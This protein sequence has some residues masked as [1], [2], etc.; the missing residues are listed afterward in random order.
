MKRI[1][2]ALSILS[3]IFV[4]FLLT[5][6]VVL[7]LIFQWNLLGFLT[8]YGISNILHYLIQFTS[9]FL[10]RRK[11]ETI[12]ENVEFSDILENKYGVLVVGHQ[13][14][15][16]Y[17]R[18]CLQKLDKL[19][20]CQQIIIVQDGQ[21][22]YMSEIV[23]EIFPNCFHLNLEKPFGE[24]SQTE[25]Q[26]FI[27]NLSS[28]KVISLTQPQRGKRDAMY[29]GFNIAFSIPYLKY[30]LCTD[31]DTWIESEAPLYLKVLLDMDGKIG[32]STGNVKIFNIHNFLS[33]MIDL[34][35]WFAFNLE[36]AAQSFF[37]CVSCVSGPLGMYRLSAVKEVL[38]NWKGQTFLG[39][40]TTFGDDRHMTNLL[41]MKGYKINYT[42]KAVCY[43]ETPSEFFRWLTQQTRWGRSFIREYFLGI[44]FFHKCSWWLL[45]D[46]TYLMFY[47]LFLFVLSIK[48]LIDI[49]FQ[50]LI[51]ILAA[52][53][54]VAGIRAVYAVFVEKDL[55]YLLFSFFGIIYFF[56]LL[57]LK[58]WSALTVRVNSWGTS[59]R[60]TVTNTWL[61]CWS[62]LVWL[63]FLIYSIQ[64][65]CR[66][67][68]F[69]NT[70]PI[71]FTGLGFLLGSFLL[72]ILIFLKSR[73]RLYSTQENQEK[74]QNEVG[75]YRNQRPL[76]EIQIE[77]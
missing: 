53:I 21:E 19:I 43:T 30:L 54:L 15:E 63:V 25:K 8:V 17:F 32:A 72:G 40:P 69:R 3:N 4:I 22:D 61:D 33:L 2:N 48:T 62:I 68:D 45:Y 37:D 35:Y 14:N 77:A 51:V 47:S 56:T 58:M 7:G 12:A 75:F 66:K 36:R 9:A 24:Y 59:G 29:T 13:E 49:E 74:I 46:L 71:A 16:H 57:P 27:L 55:I 42:H 52:T 65:S 70:S 73:N 41:L 67:Y 38:E 31:S 23:R 60:K 50:A 76:T 34:K 6:P 44:T 18:K 28:D 10:N 11:M 39:K 26:E 1:V 20:D 5:V 64:E